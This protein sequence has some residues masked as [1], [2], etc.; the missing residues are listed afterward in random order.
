LQSWAALQG[1]GSAEDMVGTL[2][3]N[4]ERPGDPASAIAQ[5]TRFLHGLNV[6][7]GGAGPVAG[8]GGSSGGGGASGNWGVQDSTDV[9]DH[10]TEMKK[11]GLLTNEQCV[12][13]ATAAVGI[14][15]GGGGEGANVH[16]WRRGEGAEAG[17]LKRGTPVATFLNRAGETGDLYAGGGSGTPGAHL[18]H[19]AVFEKYLRDKTGAAIGMEVAEQYKGSGGIHE[20]NYM[21]GK[22]FGEGNAS[23]YY[24]VKTRSGG[25][26]GGAANPM[27]GGGG[28]GPMA[29][30]QWQAPDRKNRFTV[31]SN[32][33]ADIN[34]QA[35]TLMS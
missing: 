12:S 6:S 25:Y 11:K 26:L 29:M 20:K 33:G 4:Y 19:A 18:D 31:N 21:F 13:L 16:D 9:I 22:G 28:D 15:L 2:V 35:A 27:S 3:R 5:R 32:F 7:G 8:G 14:R 30:N 10:L 1:G 23:N 17:G 24:A 34:V